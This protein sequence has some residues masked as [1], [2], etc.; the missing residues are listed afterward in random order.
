MSC[1]KPP[2]ATA[3]L[4]GVWERGVGPLESV[5]ASGQEMKLAQ[6]GTLLKT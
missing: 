6:P 5:P 2:G 4:L 3:A 1:V